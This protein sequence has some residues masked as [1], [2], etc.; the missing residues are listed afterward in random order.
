MQG[1]RRAASIL[2]L[3]AL[4]ALAALAPAVPQ[5]APAPAPVI[6]T[7]DAPS[8]GA[9]GAPV[10][11]VEFGDFQCPACAQG[12]RALRRLVARNGDR[13]RW[14]FK[15]YPLRSL[16]PQA[17]MAHE[18]AVAAQEQG[19]FWEMHDLLFQNQTK[20]RRDDLFGYAEQIGLDVAAFRAAL[21][22]RRLRPRIIRDMEEARS[23]RVFATPTYFVNGA[24]HIGPRTTS[25]FLIIVKEALRGPAVAPSRPVPGRPEPAEAAAPGVPEPGPARAPR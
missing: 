5:A 6:D 21:N 14:V 8:L 7:R 24:R 19:K 16:H 11:I 17:A 10:T 3:T 20:V 2:V 15:H 23:L 4:L 13:V 1:H 12:A 9:E 25:E 18:A 22:S